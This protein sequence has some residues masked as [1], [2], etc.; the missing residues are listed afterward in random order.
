MWGCCRFK[1]VRGYVTVAHNLVQRDAMKQVAISGVPAKGDSPFNTCNRAFG[2]CLKVSD[3][4]YFET[5]LQKLIPDGQ[6]GRINLDAPLDSPTNRLDGCETFVE[7]K[8]CS[9]HDSECQSAKI[10]V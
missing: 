5:N 4:K 1:I 6:I 2:D 8:C 10:P 3:D 7:V 9:F